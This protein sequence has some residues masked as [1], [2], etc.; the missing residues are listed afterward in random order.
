[1]CR[2]ACAVAYDSFTHE[3]DAVLGQ[4]LRGQLLVMLMLAVYYSV[5]LESV[6]AGFGLADWCLYRAWPFC[7]LMLGFGVG[8]IL[9]TLAGLLEFATQRG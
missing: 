8:L 3:A 1:L 9:A 4:Y 6:W 2:R 7:A 5:G